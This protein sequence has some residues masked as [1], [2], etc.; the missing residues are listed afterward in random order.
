MHRADPRA[1]QHGHR[2]LRHQRQVNDDPVARR[3]A[4]AGQHVG[5]SAN[6][7]VQLGIGERALVARLALPDNGGFGRAG[8]EMAIQAVFRDVEP[9]ADEPFGKG[10]VPFEHDAPRHAPFQFGGFLGPEGVRV[11]GGKLVKPIIV[12]T[13]AD[14]RPL[15]KVRR[16]REHA[17]FVEVRLDVLAGGVGQAH[18]ER[19]RSN[20]HCVAPRADSQARIAKV[21]GN[22]TNAARNAGFLP[23]AVRPGCPPR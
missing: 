6:L 5:E 10:R 21:G 23:R 16:G 22:P 8:F 12:L 15:R 1:R 3:N 17:V 9:A 4:F 18:G 13:R 20:A 7:G 14:P 2:R 11:F 19:R